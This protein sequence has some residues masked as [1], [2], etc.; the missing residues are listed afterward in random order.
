MCKFDRLDSMLMGKL[1]EPK[2]EQKPENREKKRNSFCNAPFFAHC[3]G[4]NI[5]LIFEKNSHNT[6]QSRL[7]M[8]GVVYSI[9]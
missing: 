7:T 2:I 6:L 4:I 9:G 1:P 5:F 3:K 8:M